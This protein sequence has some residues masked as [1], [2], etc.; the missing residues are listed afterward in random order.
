[1]SISEMVDQFLKKDFVPMDTDEELGENEYHFYFVK[2]HGGVLFIDEGADSDD[3]DDT[4]A[5]ITVKYIPFNFYMDFT[6]PVSESTET[7]DTVVS[8][9]SYMINTL[10]AIEKSISKI[11]DSDDIDEIHEIANKLLNL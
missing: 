3:S 11:S 10:S 2:D 5:K 8:A 9:V 7:V 6:I 4:I 1:M